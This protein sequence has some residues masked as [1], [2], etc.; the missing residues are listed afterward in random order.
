MTIT[1]KD[2]EQIAALAKLHL[3]PEDSQHVQQSLNEILRMVEKI[4]R[5]DVDDAPPMRHPRDARQ[6]LRADTITEKSLKSALMALAPESDGNYYLV[7]K[8][9]KQP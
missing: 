3:T 7:P 9:V 1:R 2:V 6:A 4:R 8:V 5:A